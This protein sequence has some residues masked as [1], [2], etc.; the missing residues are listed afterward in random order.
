LPVI[1]LNGENG[2]ALTLEVDRSNPR[3]VLSR[4]GGK[5]ALA[6]ALT[7]NGSVIVL[8]DEDGLKC[9]PKLGPVA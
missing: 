4:S 2:A 9:S 5:H 1:V 8:Y 6:I 3:I 7:G